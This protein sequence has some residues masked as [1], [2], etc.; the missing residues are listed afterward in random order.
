MSIIKDGRYPIELGG[1]TRHLLF[2]LNVLDEVQDRYGDISK[3]SEKMQSIKE[4]KFLL[5]LLLNEGRGEDEPEFSE[6]EVGRMIH[7]GN[8]VEAKDSILKAFSIGT[9]DPDADPEDEENNEKNS[10][11]SE[12]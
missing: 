12:G 11:A 1:K 6:R 9:A 3:I 4:L 7:T 10:I 2:S 5:T 8:F